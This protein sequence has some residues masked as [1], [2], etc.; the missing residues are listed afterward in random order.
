MRPD[1]MPSRKRS[2]SCA[3]IASKGPPSEP[4]LL[5]LDASALV[6]LVHPERETKALVA[7]LGPGAKLVSSEIAEV[8]VLRAVGRRGG[9]GATDRA[10]SMFESVRLLPAGAH[11]RRTAGE[12]R[13]AELR[14]LDALHLATALQLGELLAAVYAYDTRLIDAARRAGLRV[15]APS[16]ENP[17]GTEAADPLAWSATPR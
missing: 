17:G 16:E 8:E 6:K 9:E 5:Y 10:R 7:S 11:V 2:R 15:L 4:K 1:R 12:L 3:K 14:S 13:P